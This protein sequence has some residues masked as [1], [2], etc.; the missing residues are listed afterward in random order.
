MDKAAFK[1]IEGKEAKEQN[2]ALNY[3]LLSCDKAKSEL[4]ASNYIL[5]KDLGILKEQKQNSDK[6]AKDWEKIAKNQKSRNLRS[7]FLGVGVG[8][9]ITFIVTSL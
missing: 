6:I 4:K 8:I 2:K 5:N 7:G 1:M 9:I 3:A